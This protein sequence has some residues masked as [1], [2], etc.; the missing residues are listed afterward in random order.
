M[1]KIIIYLIID[2]SKWN[3]SGKVKMWGSLGTICERWTFGKYSCLH[4]RKSSVSL[5]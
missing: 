3:R 5:K 4:Q 2:I 1:K